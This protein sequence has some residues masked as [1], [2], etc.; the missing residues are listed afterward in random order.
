MTIVVRFHLNN[1]NNIVNVNNQI[2][3]ALAIIMSYA[4]IYSK[5]HP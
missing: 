5:L 1:A 3:V 2:K 4:L